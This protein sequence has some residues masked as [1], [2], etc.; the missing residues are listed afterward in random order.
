M[1]ELKYLEIRGKKYQLNDDIEYK[2]IREFQKILKSYNDDTLEDP[3]ITL[4][5]MLKNAICP[6]LPIDTKNM[7]IGKKGL[8]FSEVKKLVI[9]L[10][11][12]LE[13]IMSTQIDSLLRKDKGI[14][15]KNVTEV[16]ESKIE[17]PK[18]SG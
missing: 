8:M 6:S 15:V 5:D 14:A 11:S 10:R 3:D 16:I 17:G 9:D 2:F 1:L 12:G 7:T 4:I 18:V 13:D